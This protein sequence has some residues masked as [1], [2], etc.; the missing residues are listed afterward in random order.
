TRRTLQFELS[1]KRYFVK[2]HLGIGWREI[3]KDLVQ[4]RPPVLGAR[5]EWQAVA[6]LTELGVPTMTVAAYGSRGVNP[7]RRESFIITEDLTNTISLEDYCADWPLRP[8]DRNFKRMLI[9]GIA[10]ISRTMH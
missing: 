8:P 5:N 1:G 6:R 9:T 10:D 7:A 4:F 2:H 3:F